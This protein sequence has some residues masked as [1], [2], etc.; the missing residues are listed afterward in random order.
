MVGLDMQL[1]IDSYLFAALSNLSGAP[2]LLEEHVAR[3]E[4]G[5]R[6]GRGLYDW[7][8]RD[9][10]EVRARRDQFIIDRLKERRAAGQG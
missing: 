6:T 10:A 7:S 8:T 4:L 1:A 5:A 9:P 3:G 2:A